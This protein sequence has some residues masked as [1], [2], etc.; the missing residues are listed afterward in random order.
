MSEKQNYK[1]INVE[2]K[3]EE[4]FAEREGLIT[5]SVAKKVKAKG[6]TYLYEVLATMTTKVK[7][8]ELHTP[9]IDW[10]VEQEP[11][12]RKEYIKQTGEKIEE[13]GFIKNGQLGLSPDGGKFRKNKSIKKTIEIKCPNTKNHIKYIVTNKLPSEHKDQVVHNFMVIDDLEELDFVSYDPRYKYKPLHIIRIKREDLILEINVAKVAYDAHLLKL[14]EL[15][16][17]LVL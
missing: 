14:N 5:G 1:I 10:G 13:I 4:W 11:N 2:Q 16:R 6:D 7:E 17:K 12:A 3:T 8:K 9:A 15:Y